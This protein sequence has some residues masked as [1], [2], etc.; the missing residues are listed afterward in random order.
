MIVKQKNTDDPE[1]L[2]AR[3]L[4]QFEIQEM[5]EIPKNLEILLLPNLLAEIR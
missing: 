5:L 2:A 4:W 3:N 1:I